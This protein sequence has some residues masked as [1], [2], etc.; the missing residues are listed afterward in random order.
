MKKE[1]FAKIIGGKYR[2]KKIKLPPKEITRSSKNVLRESLFNILQFDVLDKNFIEVF[3]GS[4]SVGLEALSRGAKHI[5]FIEINKESY[6]VLSKNITL[7]DKNSCTLLFGDAFEKIFDIIK[8]LQIKKEKGY[9]YFDPP[10]SIREGMKDIYNKVFKLIEKI[11]TEVCEMV[12]IEHMTN[13]EL[14]E[15]I[16]KFKLIKQKKFGKSSLSFY[17][18]ELDFEKE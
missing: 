10:F 17:N 14:P 4:G 5:Y 8:E 11:P 7:L 12:I 3:G 16:N 6:N 1:L 13:I 9:F 2:G 15:R 18:L